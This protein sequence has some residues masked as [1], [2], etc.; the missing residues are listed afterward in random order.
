MCVVCLCASAFF[1][2]FILIKTF[3]G[4]PTELIRST[5]YMQHAL[6]ILFV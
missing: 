3:M 6:K 1:I 2:N 5:N 4:L